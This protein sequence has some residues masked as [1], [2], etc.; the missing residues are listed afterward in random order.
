MIKLFHDRTINQGGKMK[1]NTKKLYKVKSK[2]ITLVA[3]V[4]T[5]IILLIL[6]GITIN[7][8]IGQRGILKM[9]ESTRNEQQYAQLKEEL[10]MEIINIKARKIAEGKKM[11]K[12]NLYELIAIGVQINSMENLVEGEYKNYFFEIDENYVVTI[13]GKTQG[14]KPNI[15]G[16]IVTKGPVQQ[17]EKI[18]IKVTASIKEGSIESIVATNGA[19]LKQT[20]DNKSTEKFYEVDKNGIY[21]FKTVA[22]NNRSNVVE[23]KVNSIK[24]KPQISIK[25]VNKEGFTIVLMNDYA[26]EIITD[27]QYYVG[28]KPQPNEAIRKGMCC[29]RISIWYRI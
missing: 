12:E 20:T 19:V 18:E 26:D 24:E 7:L 23:V 3:L 2:G 5:I 13:I 21:Y 29:F 22:S 25:N 16:E 14:E 11:T 1:K 27:I 4:I 9:A 15:I 28:E 17:G 8:T 6:A 10:E